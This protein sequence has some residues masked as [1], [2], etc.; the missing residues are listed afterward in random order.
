MENL[1]VCDEGCDMHSNSNYWWVSL[2]DESSP[3]WLCELRQR[4]I[5]HD[6]N[7]DEFVGVVDDRQDGGEIVWAAAGWDLRRGTLHDTDVTQE[8]KNHVNMLS[9]REVDNSDSTG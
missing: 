8:I 4:E 2:W 7:V 1:S 3:E 5:V 6:R 9:Q